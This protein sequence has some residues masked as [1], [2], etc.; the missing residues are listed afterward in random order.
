[1]KKHL[2]FFLS[3]AVLLMLVYTPAQAANSA[4]TTLKTSVDTVISLLKKQKETGQSQRDQIKHVMADIFDKTELS[5]RALGIAWKNFTP[6]Q[7][8]RFVTAFVT[9]LDKT[10]VDKLDGFSG[11]TVIFEH[12]V[13]L[14]PD[15]AEV[16]TKIVRNSGADIP[17]VYRMI[18]ND[19]VWRIYDVVIEGVSLVRNYR[20]QFNSLLQNTTPDK[21]IEKINSMA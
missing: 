12:E 18:L 1:M 21:L 11:E 10:Y 17:I 3:L 7:Q 6:D 13:S 8:A 2:S 16:A 4:T 20:K 14:G 19:G 9:L 15:K 5:R